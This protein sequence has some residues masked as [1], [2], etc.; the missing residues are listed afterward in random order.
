MVCLDKVRF[1]VGEFI[2]SLRLS[3]KHQMSGLSCHIP[4]T[5]QIICLRGIVPFRLTPDWVLSVRRN[6]YSSNKCVTI[7]RHRQL[8]WLLTDSVSENQSS[9]TGADIPP[10][11]KPCPH[12]S[13]PLLCMTLRPSV[14]RFGNRKSPADSSHQRFSSTMAGKKTDSPK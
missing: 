12:P 7:P 13:S 2:M 4:L 8:T 5:A 1:K 14:S 9:V 11:P 6:N 3:S 10:P